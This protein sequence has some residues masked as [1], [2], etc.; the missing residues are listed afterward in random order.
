MFFQKRITPGHFCESIA[1]VGAAIAYTTSLFLLSTSFALGSGNSKYVGNPSGFGKGS[2]K[3]GYVKYM[4][5]GSQ[6]YAPPKPKDVVVVP[7]AAP[8]SAEPVAAPSVEAPPPEDTPPSVS[9]ETGVGSSSGEGGGEGGGTGSE[10]GETYWGGD[11]S[12]SEEDFSTDTGMSSMMPITISWGIHENAATTAHAAITSSA[13]YSSGLAKKSKDDE[14]EDDSD[15]D[16]PSAKKFL[17][18]SAARR[19]SGRG[20]YAPESLSGFSSATLKNYQAGGYTSQNAFKHIVESLHGEGGITL[21]GEG[22]DSSQAE[23]G[24][25]RQAKSLRL[26]VSGAYARGL[27]DQ[28]GKNASSSDE[29]DSVFMTLDQSSPATGQIFGVLLGG[30]LGT[31]KVSNDVNGKGSNKSATVGFYYNLTLPKNIQWSVSATVTELFSKSNRTV[32]ASA[33]TPSFV[34]TSRNKTYSSSVTNGLS[35]A[36]SLTETFSC[37]PSV[38]LTYQHTVQPAYGDRNAGASSIYHAGQKTDVLK[39]SAGLAV[40]EKILTETL[41]VRVKSAF[42]YSYDVNKQEAKAKTFTIN[43]PQAGTVTSLPSPGRGLLSINGGLDVTQRGSNWTF[44]TTVGAS[45][46]D[47]RKS[48]NVALRV[49]KVF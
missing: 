4:V 2:N 15:E 18:F 48:Y 31:S 11:F 26:K 6:P 36:F 21:H 33:S 44:G 28:M 39:A 5:Q 25:P 45:I 40:E 10:G 37:T 17:A 30:G 16:A 29:H 27:T 24:V 3:G 8:V 34:A 9:I 23:G 49:T 47:H 38:G 20:P 13:A 12:A 22:G 35:H 41:D 43:G 7:V 1:N 42:L 46:Q 19:G 32:A 14:N